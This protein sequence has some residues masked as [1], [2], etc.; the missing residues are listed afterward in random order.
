MPSFNHANP[1]AY[2]DRPPPPPTYVCTTDI[3][4]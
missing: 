4:S 2:L 1:R 3:E